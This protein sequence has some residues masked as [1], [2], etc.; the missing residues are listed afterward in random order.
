[1]GG[2]KSQLRRV[3]SG[4]AFALSLPSLRK[5]SLRGCGLTA[6]LLSTA[7]AISEERFH[8]VKPTNPCVSC[9][10]LFRSSP[11][12]FPPNSTLQILDLLDMQLSAGRFPDSLENLKF[13]TGGVLDLALFGNFKELS[14]LDISD[15]RQW[16]SDH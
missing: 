16:Q 12:E 11:P 1:M 13:L 2:Q 8:V 15:N 14:H 3:V 10:S 9:N 5:L 7:W 4:V 6:E